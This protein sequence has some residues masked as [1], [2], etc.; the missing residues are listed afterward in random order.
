MSKK[1]RLEKLYKTKETTFCLNN[2]NKICRYRL[3]NYEQTLLQENGIALSF[4]FKDCD[5]NL[6]KHYHL[7]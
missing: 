1:S 7:D 6:F 4:E 2:C 5:N 3:S